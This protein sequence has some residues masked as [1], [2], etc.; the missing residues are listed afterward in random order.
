MS[1][2]PLQ[3]VVVTRPAGQEATLMALLRERGFQPLHLPSL[4]IEPLALSAADTQKLVNVDLYHAVFFASTNAVKLA[5]PILED[6]WPQWPL[7]VHWLAV[8]SATAAALEQ[9]GLPVQAPSYGMDSEAVLELEVLR[10][11][12]GNKVLI[13]RG[14][15]GRGFLKEQLE[16]R[17]AQV[18]VLDL[19]QRC[20]V[21]EW[22]WPQADAILINSVQSWQAVS[23]Q[24][25]TT[26]AVIAA[27]ERIAQ[28]VQQT[29][30]RV[31]VAASALDLDMAT[32]LQTI[33]LD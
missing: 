10:E 30:A 14:N 21:V 15:Q 17:G 2:Q 7:G 16:S 13:C 28:V 22:R 23:A 1:H 31:T 29:H 19:Y 25:P 8:G 3:S 20:A 9:A 11:V 33:R 27:S 6:Y 32:T 18:D 12:A 4:T 24:V 26:A 5:L